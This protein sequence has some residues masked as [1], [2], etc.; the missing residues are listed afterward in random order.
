MLRQV[1][2]L[3]RDCIMYS[4]PGNIC[5]YPYYTQDLRDETVKDSF[6]TEQTTKITET[7]TGEFGIYDGSGYVQKISPY[8]TSGN[9][10]AYIFFRSIIKDNFRRENFMQIVKKLQEN[11][12]IDLLTQ[13]LILQFNLYNPNQD[14]WTSVNLVS[15]FFFKGGILIFDLG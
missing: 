7:I 4:K 10:S 15:L 13:A 5:T 6:E 8:K 9:F 2:I 11:S 14:L 1:K 3:E 12:Y